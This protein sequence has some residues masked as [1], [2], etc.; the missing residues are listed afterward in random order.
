MYAAEIDERVVMQIGPGD[1]VPDPAY[2][3][4]GWGHLL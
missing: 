3:I 1:F 2:E 4:G